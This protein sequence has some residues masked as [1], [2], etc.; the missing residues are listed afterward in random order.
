M[1]SAESIFKRYLGVETAGGASWHPSSTKIAFVYDAPGFYQI[2]TTE[3][4]EGRTIW[5][6]RITFENDR[7]TEVKYLSDG[8]LIFSMD[9]G[10]NENFQ[11]GHVSNRGELKW[12]TT[13]LDAKHRISHVD[14][15]GFYYLANIEDKA[16]LDIYRHRVPIE[17]NT[18]ELLIRPK[19]GVFSL[20]ATSESGSFALIQQAEGNA[21][22]NLF[23]LN[24]RTMK[25]IPL[26]A[27]INKR[28]TRWQAIK[29][30]DDTHF[31]VNTD[32]KSDFKRLAVLS[33]DAGFHT[34]DVIERSFQSSC[35]TAV[36][37]K[38]SEYVYFALNE[39]G[40]NRVF[41]GRFK[42]SS[43]SEVNEIR[44]PMRGVINS[45]DQRSFS[46]GM[47]LSPDGN[48]LA[49]SISTSV[50]S[51]NVWIV[52]T[53]TMNTWKATNSQMMGLS[54]SDF[55]SETL[56]RFDSFDGLSVP[57]FRYLPKGD[58]PKNGWPALFIIHGGPEAQI[59]PEFNPVIQFYLSAGYAVVTPNIRGSTG[60][61]RRYMDLDNIE[62]RLDSIKD[63]AQLYHHIK[64]HD[65]KIDSS[66]IVIYGGSY[67]G[68]A[69]LSS[70]TEFP[71]LWAAAVDIVG[72]SNFVT[73][74][75]N[76]A[77]WRRTLRESEYGSLETHVEVLKKISPIHKVNRILCPL[78]IIQGDNDE[79][80]PLSESI[81]IYEMVK[82]KG[83][84]VEMMRFA[85]EGHGLSKLSNRIKAYSRVVEWLKEIV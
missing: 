38:G 35:E 71:D 24:L 2:F 57:Y 31:L 66:R 77:K 75:Q 34:Y 48:K 17:G 8:S 72:I 21:K 54:P 46:K 82:A 52:N 73:F 26:T 84:P 23:L 63:I 39:E 41:R 5:P 6:N 76:T 3:I 9:A 10:G 55:S 83:I 50:E 74:L 62:K 15:S 36:A 47:S 40:Y 4:D 16:R 53:Q 42:K 11:I 45:G 44:L 18:P 27:S 32:H 1:A 30:L 69:V 68:F 67:G 59:R 19:S 56:L 33:A 58:M 49:I 20:Q 85:D 81:Q 12:I 79:R 78:F 28:D 61:G 70:I 25:L 13:D 37:S 14:D 65:S 51:S 29:F 80:V 7:C 22:Q 43:L 64:E 60:Y